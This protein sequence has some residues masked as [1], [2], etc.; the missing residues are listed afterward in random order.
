MSKVALGFSCKFT[1]A[2]SYT[3]ITSTKAREASPLQ[4]LDIPQHVLKESSVPIEIIIE[5]KELCFVSVFI[6]LCLPPP[7]LQK[8][9]TRSTH[10]GTWG[11]VKCQAQRPRAERL[12]GSW[13]VESSFNYHPSGCTVTRDG[14]RES[15]RVLAIQG[16]WI[17]LSKCSHLVPPAEEPV[18]TSDKQTENMPCIWPSILSLLCLATRQNSEQSC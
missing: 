17:M 15:L 10:V 1:P 4:L 3:E 13:R 12:A 7:P 8:P 2:D 5:Q 14:N 16:G 6:F 11:N 18:T 9:S